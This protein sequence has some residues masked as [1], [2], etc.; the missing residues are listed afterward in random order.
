M[1]LFNAHTVEEALDIL[2]NEIK[3]YLPKAEEIDLLS[4]YNRV[5][6]EDIISSEDIP[7]FTRSAVDGFAVKA[8]DTYGASES[9]PSILRIVGEVRM[10]QEAD[11]KLL[12]GETVKI[13]TGGMLP[14]G[15]DSVV[16]LEYTQYLDDQTLCIERPVAPGDNLIYK[17]E[18]IKNGDI[19]LKK[20][21]TLRPQDLGVLAGLGISKVSVIKP[22]IV[23][24]ISTGDEVKPPGE[25]IGPGEVRDINTYAISGQTLKWGA[26]PRAF[27]IIRD[28]FHELK[29]AV[30]EALNLSDLV[31]ISGGSSV[32]TRDHTVGVIEAL[33]KPG[34]LVHGLPVKPG[35]PTILA[36]TNGKPIIGLPGHPVSAMVIFE[37]IV[38]PV[39]SMMLQRP[40][41]YG[42]KK[43][44]AKIA[45]NIASAA[46]RQDFIRVR[47]EKRGNELWAVPVLGKSGL[48]S[49]MV[50]SHGLAEIPPEKQGVSEGEMVEIEL[51]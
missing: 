37:L 17:G 4:A 30:E 11:I 29:A 27:G 20:G 49:T 26:I 9:L 6:S 13:P 45:R 14:E 5:L 31:I 51:F 41:E 15:S 42:N 18:D 28:D 23:S 3:G 50:E 44:F 36:A 48:I 25:V 32:G 1:T 8:K 22:P 47:I 19:V 38:R 33:G 21:H 2:N 39:I 24:I 43:I 10:G 40:K 12:Q 35:K 34:L 46:G 7:S 16:M